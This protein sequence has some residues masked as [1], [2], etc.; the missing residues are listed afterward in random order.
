M[1]TACARPRREREFRFPPELWRHIR[2]MGGCRE[3]WLG[4]YRGEVVPSVPRAEHRFSFVGVFTARGERRITCYNECA[5]RT[6]L[7]RVDSSGR[8][9]K[10]RR[11]RRKIYEICGM[12][13][14]PD[15]EA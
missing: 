9:R 2:E 14:I 4:R 11:P 10:G 6:G 3:F 15:T 1:E 12:R 7:R 8:V 13:V 5:L